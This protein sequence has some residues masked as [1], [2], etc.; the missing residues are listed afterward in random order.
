MKRNRPVDAEDLVMLAELRTEAKDAYLAAKDK[1]DKI[2]EAGGITRQ[3][4]AYNS[5][6]VLG[7]RR[8]TDIIFNS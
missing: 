3:F 4:I 5:R 7:E 1:V 6:E 2:V 8:S